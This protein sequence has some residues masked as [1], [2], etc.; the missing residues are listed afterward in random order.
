MDPIMIVEAKRST[1]SVIR[2]RNRN[3]DMIIVVII[4]EKSVNA[5]A[6]RTIDHEKNA[7]A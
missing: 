3:R 5:I 6:K 7:E 2:N 1:Q 4:Y